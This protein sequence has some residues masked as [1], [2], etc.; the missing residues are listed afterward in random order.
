MLFCLVVPRTICAQVEICDNGIDDDNDNLVDLNDED[1]ICE[2]I[3]PKSLIPN[4]SFEEMDCCPDDRS[5]LDC[6]SSWIQASDPTTDF[7]H[8][9]DWLGWDDFPPPQPFPDGN[10]IMGFRDGR[11]R[12]NNNPEPYW[13]EYAGACLISPLETDSSYRFQFDVGFVDPQKSPPI[14]ISFF[15]TPSC[16]YLPFGKG[17]AA[18]GCPSNSPNWT[19]LGEV[20]VSGGSGGT[21]INTFLEIVPEEDIY[22]IAIGP[23]CR[24]ISSPVSIYYFFDNLLLANLELFDLQISEI[25]HP[26]SQDFVL[27]V[28][29]N[30]DF[31]YQWYLSGIALEGEVFSE[32]TQNYGEGPYQVRILDGT[33]CRISATFDY[34]IPIYSTPVK[35]AICKGDSYVFGDLDL[36]EPG[37]Y[38]DTLRT[39]DNCD[40]IVALELELIGQKYD[41]IEVSILGSEIF[42][43]G[44][45]S[46]GEAGDYEL[47]F[48][49]SIG[50]D[51]LVFLKL[52]HFNV[53]IPNAF[54]PNN[55]GVNDTFHPFGPI[56][57][58]KS[59][60]MEIFDRWGNLLYQGTEWDGSDLRP[61]V[62]VYLI[63]IDFEFGNSKSYSGSVTLLK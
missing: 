3:E 46:F 60:E 13:K 47:T 51:S 53:Y 21:W 58:I 22:A 57:E 23:D 38:L 19:K 4:P 61:G 31:D 44:E 10:G 56:G 41:T 30:P 37:F 28:P 42:Q 7:I 49:S 15:G 8:L 24:P 25:S 14:D 55:D 18:F 12:S 54:S 50:C 20:S 36:S 16:D 32:L 27:S 63:N 34:Q 45:Y 1:C 40:S 35:A 5:Q 11:V 29:N 33:T 62:F 59:F 26:C 52:S 17:N 6:A 43:I 39:Q 48:T 2:I 9:C